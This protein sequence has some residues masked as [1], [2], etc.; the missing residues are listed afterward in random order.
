[1]VEKLA[2]FASPLADQAKHNHIALDVTGNLRQQGG[3]ATAGTG[4]Q[5]HTLPLAKRQQAIDRAHPS[6]QCAMDSG[7]FGRQRRLAQHHACIG[8]VDLDKRTGANAAD[9][10]SKTIQHLTQK[11][12]T[13]QHSMRHAQ[14]LHAGAHAYPFEIAQGTEYGVLLIETDDLSQHVVVDRLLNLAQVTDTRVGQTA[15][16]QH[17]IHALHSTAHRHRH[18]VGQRPSL[19]LLPGLQAR[20]QVRTHQRTS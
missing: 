14:T 4:K 13:D 19:A 10:P 12:I 15:L 17:A 3:L 6:R 7:P 5:P 1:M 18:E 8:T 16:Q 20:L 2:Q 11:L 9:R